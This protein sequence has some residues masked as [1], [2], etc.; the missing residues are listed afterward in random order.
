MGG[1]DRT[2]GVELPDIWVGK[3][4]QIFIF[5]P[6]ELVARPVHLASRLTF[7]ITGQVKKQE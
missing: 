3:T 2:G 4:D 6:G 7:K 5:K 1:S